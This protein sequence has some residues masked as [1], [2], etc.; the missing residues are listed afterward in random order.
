[1]NS[2]KDASKKKK[3]EAKTPDVRSKMLSID[4]KDNGSVWI[5]LIFAET[6]N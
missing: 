3:K 5:Q 1:M 6:E 4:S 2:A